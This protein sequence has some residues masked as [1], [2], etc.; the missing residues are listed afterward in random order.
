M[1][2]TGG[3]AGAVLAGG[4]SSRM[5][6][7][8]ALIDLGPRR[9]IEVAI[10]ALWQAGA[11]DV[12]VVGGDGD[13]ITALGHHW[14]ADRHRGEGPLGGIITALDAAADDPVVVL[15]CDHVA[16]DARAV[17]ALLGGLGTA[18]LAMPIVHGRPQTMHAVWRRR[19]LGHLTRRFEAGDRAVYRAID[20]LAVVMVDGLDPSWFLDA[21]T[22]DDLPDIVIEG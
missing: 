10:D 20:G 15:A 5:G 18:D 1:R 17:Y 2:T 16:A 19:T 11:T 4:R 21:D 7:D 8:K 22:P 14:V 12:V 13:A 6:R 9:L 3:F